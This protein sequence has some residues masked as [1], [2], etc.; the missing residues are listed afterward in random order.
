MF[1][2]IIQDV[3]S[4]ARIE[5]QKT[6]THMWFR[7]RLN[8]ENWN[9]GDSVAADGCCLTITDKPDPHTW[10]ATLSQETLNLTHFHQ[11]KEGQH[12]NLE[13]ALRAG[14]PLGGHIV[15]GHIDGLATL[16]DLQ[17][18]G[19]HRLMTFEVPEHLAKYLVTKGSVAL[20]GVSLTVN[21]V[22]G[23]TFSVNLIPHTLQAT[24]LRVLIPGMKTNLETDIL[25]RYIERISFYHEQ[26][27]S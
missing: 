5:R 1:T 16:I 17:T 8:T 21:Q 9:I 3:G 25:G 20:N 12:I 7:T 10:Q 18:I 6:Q 26:R 4:I 19:E 13:A 27:A 22:D 11:A 2:G 14:D 23:C 15:T 24:N